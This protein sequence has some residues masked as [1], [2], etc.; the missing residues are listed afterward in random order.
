[1]AGSWYEVLHWSADGG[2]AGHSPSAVWRAL[3]R[4][5]PMT[6]SVVARLVRSGDLRLLSR[7]FDHEC[8]DPR[9]A[10]AVLTSVPPLQPVQCTD[11]GKCVLQAL[12]VI[13]RQDAGHIWSLIQHMARE[14]ASSAA[15][16]TMAGYRACRDVLQMRD[17]AELIALHELVAQSSSAAALRAFERAALAQLP[18]RDLADVRGYTALR[19]ARQIDDYSGAA[20]AS[21]RAECLAHCA[22]LG[23]FTDELGAVLVAQARRG[24][25]RS[26]GAADVLLQHDVLPLQEHEECV[27]VTRQIDAMAA[28]LR[29]DGVNCAVD[30][31]SEGV[32]CLVI[33]GDETC[34]L[35]AA[36]LLRR[37]G[38]ASDAEARYDE[39]AGL[40]LVDARLQAA[41]AEIFMLGER[42]CAPALA[43]R[44]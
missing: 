34:A 24:H 42:R 4:R 41:D 15:M 18:A 26:P 13:T 7:A 28:S 23:G 21:R 6:A 37:S 10:E 5:L 44:P 19:L 31:V 36:R 14:G 39:D 12:D 8:V 32:V 3:N 11:F 9:A 20:V 25:L 35:G 1:M 43:E 16:A 2:V 38:L 29:V 17:E 33:E 27:R 22:T 30:G 40:W